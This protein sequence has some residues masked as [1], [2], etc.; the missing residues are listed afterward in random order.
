MDVPV[1]VTYFRKKDLVYVVDKPV[2]YSEL[3]A[4]GETREEIIE[5]LLTRCNELGKMQFAIPEGTKELCLGGE[6]AEE[7]AFTKA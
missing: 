3:S 6:S 5:K 4:N 1:Y 7:S 2:L